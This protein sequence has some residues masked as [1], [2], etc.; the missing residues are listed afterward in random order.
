MAYGSGANWSGTDQ[1]GEAAQ[2]NWT[3]DASAAELEAASEVEKSAL[4]SAP[5]TIP[6]RATPA[7]AAERM[8]TAWNRDHPSEQVTLHG[9]TVRW[10]EGTDITNMSFTVNNGSSHEVPGLGNAVPVYG[11]LTVKNIS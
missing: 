3:T 6:A 8:A 4:A 11:G 10:P 7:V 9:S 2:V 1:S 5:F